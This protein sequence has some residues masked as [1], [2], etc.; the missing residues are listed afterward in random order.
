MKQRRISR[1]LITR[2]WIPFIAGGA[3]LQINLT[4]CDQEVRDAVLTGVQ[5]SMTGMI[6][7]I[8]NAFF[9]SLQGVG[10]GTTTQPV[11]QAAFENL[12]NLFA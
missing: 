2:R 4:G 12:R 8:I 11:V 1:W 10:S 7:A 5:T 9:L 3:A 6:T